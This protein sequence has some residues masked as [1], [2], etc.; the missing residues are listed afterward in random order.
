MS[1]VICPIRGGPGSKTTIETAIQLAKQ[2]TM[3]LT[4]L[5]V[6]NLDFMTH[7]ESS[8]VRTVTTE[9]ESMGDF[10]LISAK[11]EA[12]KKGVE[13]QSEIRH[14]NVGE[15]IVELS[16]ELE[17][18]FLVMGRPGGE[19]EENVFDHERLEKFIDRIEEESGAKVIIAQGDAS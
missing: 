16:H 18:D 11:A 14:G 8:R 1:G 9:L 2:E 4:F 13:A 3:P 15:Q 19:A 7:T 12:E 17:A 6:V 10:I 5:Y